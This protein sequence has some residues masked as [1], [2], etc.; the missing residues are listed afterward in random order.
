MPK[1]VP[2]NKFWM[3]GGHMNQKRYIDLTEDD[4]ASVARCRGI[5]DA[6]PCKKPIFRCAECGNYGCDQEVV[7]KCSAQGF[8]N[9]KCLHCGVTGS[10]VP[11]MQ[12]DFDMYVAQWE[13]EV[14]VV[15]KV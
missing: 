5:K 2:N 4:K 8:K 7:D 13:K 1:V 15:K 6:H 12:K 11:V 14:P 3:R 10:R 9:D